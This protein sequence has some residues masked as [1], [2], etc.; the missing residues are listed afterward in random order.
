MLMFR[1]LRS[2]GVVALF[3]RGRKNVYLCLF[4][5]FFAKILVFRSKIYYICRLKLYAL[6]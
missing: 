3:A 4:V 5:I 2:W 6:I 1:L